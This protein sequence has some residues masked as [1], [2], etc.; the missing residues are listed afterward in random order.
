MSEGKTGG[1][2]VPP[3]W[4]KP[5]GTPLSCREKLKVLNEN[6]EELRQM[7]QD[8]LEDAIVMGCDEAQ[9]RETLDRLIASLENPYK[10]GQER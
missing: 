2:F 5:D 9:V 7:A 10:S 3:T 1:R 8:A 6:L 4:R